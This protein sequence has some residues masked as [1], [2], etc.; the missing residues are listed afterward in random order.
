[1][2]LTETLGRYPFE[3]PRPL[4]GTLTYRPDSLVPYYGEATDTTR[5]THDDS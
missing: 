4:A 3:F 5:V 1:M 2:M